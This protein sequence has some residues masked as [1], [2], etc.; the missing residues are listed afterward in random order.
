MFSCVVLDQ[1]FED[2]NLTEGIHKLFTTLLNVYNNENIEQ[3][4][5]KLAK[6]FCEIQRR[7]QV[8]S[9]N[10]DNNDIQLQELQNYYHCIVFF[11][12]H[13]HGNDTKRTRCFVKT[14][15]LNSLYELLV[16]FDTDN[17]QINQNQNIV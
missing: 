9:D 10:N 5:Q 14:L 11:L 12:T 16:K 6:Y 17:Y 8:P 4:I 7:S 13:L 3:K 2:S 15:A 1:N